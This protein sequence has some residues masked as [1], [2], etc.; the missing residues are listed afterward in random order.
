MG[1]ACRR[2]EPGHIPRGVP[3]AEN[4]ETPRHPADGHATERK[5]LFNLIGAAGEVDVPASMQIVA[6]AG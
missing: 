1:M 6:I 4:P 5:Y 3:R 2:R